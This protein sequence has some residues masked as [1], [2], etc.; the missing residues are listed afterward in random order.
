MYLSARSWPTEQLS[1][2]K[3]FGDNRNIYR[4]PG[5]EGL[6]ADGSVKFQDGR[7][8]PCIDT[9]LFATGY[10]YDF[11][12]LRDAAAVTVEDNRYRL[13]PPSLHTEA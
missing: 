13:S 12:F 9:V 8:V 5:F 4:M 6:S 2:S 11:P 7:E 1:N 3:P 10:K